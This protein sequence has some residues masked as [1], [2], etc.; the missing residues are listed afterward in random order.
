MDDDTMSFR[1]AFYK[2]TRPGIP[3]IYNWAVRQW[4]SGPYSHVELV[5]SDGQS[6]SSS[7][8][9]GGTRFKSI[10][11]T[12]GDWDI[13]E[14]P[15]AWEANARAYFEKH[16]KAR[17]GY[18]LLGNMRFLFGLVKQSSKKLFCSEAAAEALSLDT[19]WRYEPNVL[20][21]AVR[22]MVEV[23]GAARRAP[24]PLAA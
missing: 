15:A 19:A 8:E 10:A 14:L 11:Y 23:H 24:R 18:D 1:I 7:F 16:V 9:D 17:T 2:G 13:F 22:R 5:F 6:A 4:T 3:G 20:D 12:S 21:S